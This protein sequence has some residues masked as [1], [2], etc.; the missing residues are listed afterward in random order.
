MFIQPFPDEVTRQ[1]AIEQAIL[2][3]GDL[4]GCLC[5]YVEAC[6][7]HLVRVAAVGIDGWGLRLVTQVVPA[8][9]FDPKQKAGFEVSGCWEIVSVSDRSVQTSIWM[10]LTRYDLVQAVISA[11][12]Q[13][14][15]GEDLALHVHKL[16]YGLPEE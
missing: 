9:G 15:I 6:W 1:K 4:T 2:D 5:V 3:L 16:A 8:E 11:A 14:L 7:V 12:E 13:G 10:L